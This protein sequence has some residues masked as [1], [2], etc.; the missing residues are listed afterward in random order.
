MA[1]WARMATRARVPISFLIAAVSLWLA[2][3]TS[4]SIAAGAGFA[5]VGLCLRAIASG[6][7]DKNVRL[8]VTGPYAY[9]RHPL[10]LGSVLIAIGFVMAARSWWVAL[11]VGTLFLAIY[12]PVIKAEEDYLRANFAGYADYEAS[13]PGFGLRIT[14]YQAGVSDERPRFSRA[15]YLWHREY[16]AV[17]CALL[18][19][20]ALLLKLL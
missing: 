14:P 10:Y 1:S 16:N 13:V 3:P 15:L 2:Q 19:L 9:T 6:Y 7:I 12:L 4:L 8:A 18:M 20:G 5:L 17:L 11:A